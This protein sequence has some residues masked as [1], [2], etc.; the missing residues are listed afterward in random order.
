MLLSACISDTQRMALS[1]GDTR[2]TQRTVQYR[3]STSKVH[4]LKSPKSSVDSLVVL[5]I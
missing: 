1:Y 3:R 2:D 5:E 4:K